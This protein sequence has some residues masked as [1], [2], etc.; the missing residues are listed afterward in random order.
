MPI[1]VH[2]VTDAEFKTWIEQAKKNAG[3]IPPNPNE[4][5]SANRPVNP[6]RLA[7]APGLANPPG[8]A[9]AN[10]LAAARI[11]TGNVQR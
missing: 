9:N 11:D 8:L 10:V 4:L 5:A 2:A 3:I 6:G 1:A 7:N